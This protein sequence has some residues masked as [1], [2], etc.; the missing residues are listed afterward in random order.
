M[1][2]K[3][4]LLRHFSTNQ[5][6]SNGFGYQTK[7]SKTSLVIES[8]DFKLQTLPKNRLRPISMKLSI[9]LEVDETFMMM[10]L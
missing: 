10:W 3:I 1:I 5:K 7:I 9:M 4:Y 6:N 2:L 8:R